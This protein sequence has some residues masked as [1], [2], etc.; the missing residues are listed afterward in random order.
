MSDQINKQHW[1]QCIKFLELFSLMCYFQSVMRVEC[2]RILH[3]FACHS[4]SWVPLRL[5]MRTS[6]ITF[7]ASPFIIKASGDCDQTWYVRGKVNTNIFG[8]NL[9]WSARSKTSFLN[10]IIYNLQTV[11][12]FS[13]LVYS[14]VICS[15]NILSFAIPK[16][17]NGCQV[18]QT[19]NLIA[20]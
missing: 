17:E 3:V 6:L 11:H 14:C 7:H 8:Q 1:V 13:V 10:N 16:L 9:T 12:Y 18:N 5:C 15:K 20:H 19:Q 4:K 2:F